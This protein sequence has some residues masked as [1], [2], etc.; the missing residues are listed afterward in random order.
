MPQAMSGDD[1]IEPV[2]RPVLLEEVIRS[3]E[4]APGEKYV[5]ATL[6]QAGHSLEIAR[7]GGFVLGIEA[8]PKTLAWTKNYI[9]RL[10]DKQIE[11]RIRAVP[12]NFRDLQKIADENGFR[13]IS[14]VLFDLG[15]STYELNQGG[16]G[17]S[18]LKD[19]FLDMRLNPKV[20]EITAS[21]LINSLEKGE[22]Y[23]VF[24]K[25]GEERDAER[26]SSAIVR[27]RRI[28]KV[29]TTFDLVSLVESAYQPIPSQ[30]EIYNHLAKVFQSL[31]I[32]VNGELGSLREAL[33]QAFR[34]LRG[35]GRICVISF[36]S[37]EDRIVKET[38]AGWV[39]G[40]A[41]VYLNR[42]PVGADRFQ[43]SKNRSARSAKLRV[44]KKF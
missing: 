12:G 23:G 36:H 11:S 31:R 28:K 14:G 26:I 8:N 27:G 10:D 1:S 7:K 38:F 22:L 5:D 42:K 35:G 2:H 43:I 25:F 41:G 19:E 6:G 21:G 24:T 9:N 13:E 44:F 16:L 34:L 3:V 33:P 29:K 4:V 37:L 39:R 32:T 17:F 18:F 20:Q 40:G 15:L 30:R